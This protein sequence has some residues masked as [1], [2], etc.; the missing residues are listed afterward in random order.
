MGDEKMRVS[1]TLSKETIKTKDGIRTIAVIAKVYNG[2][3]HIYIQEKTKRTTTPSEEE[4]QRRCKF[5]V[6]STAGATLRKRFGI[7]AYDSASRRILY[8]ACGKIFDRLTTANGS[9]PYPQEVVDAVIAKSHIPVDG[10]QE[11]ILDK[12]RKFVENAE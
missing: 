9:E 4:M 3:Q 7:R 6:C 5:A 8:A 10:T 2:K 11:L 12:L 1:G